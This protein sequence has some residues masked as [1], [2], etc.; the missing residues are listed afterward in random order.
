MAL[1]RSTGF[2][3][4]T[5]LFKLTTVTCA[6]RS[7]IFIVLTLFI[8]LASFQALAGRTG[9]GVSFSIVAKIFFGKDTFFGAGT[10]F[11]FAPAMKNG[12]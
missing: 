12:P 5:L 8:K 10:F 11:E 9:K 1:K 7:N 4:G 3:L 6:C 2:G